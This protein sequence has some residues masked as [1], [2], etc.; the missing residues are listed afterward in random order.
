MIGAGLGEAKTLAGIGK[1]GRIAE[2]AGRLPLGDLGEERHG[3]APHSGELAE[4]IHELTVRGGCGIHA[5]P[6]GTGWREEA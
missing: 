5:G 2:G 3:A 1:H 4:G 6:P